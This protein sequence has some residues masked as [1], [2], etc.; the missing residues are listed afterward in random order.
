MAEAAAAVTAIDEYP[1]R[2]RKLRDS[3]V[4]WV[5]A[6]A[7]RIP[8]YCPICNGQC[9]YGAQPHDAPRRIP[10]EALSAARNSVTG[11]AVQLLLRLYDSGLIGKPEVNRYV[12][13]LR[14]PIEPDDLHDRARSSRG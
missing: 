14:L 4:A 9:A 5:R 6:R 3:Q 2:F 1:V 12:D 7:L 13:A 11:S 10:S 8:L